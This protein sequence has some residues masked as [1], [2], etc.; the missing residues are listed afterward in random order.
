MTFTGKFFEAPSDGVLTDE[1]RRT[2]EATN[3]AIYKFIE[4]SIPYL[5]LADKYQTDSIGYVV[6]LNY[7]CARNYAISYYMGGTDEGYHEKAFLFFG[8]YEPPAF[9]AHEILHLFGA[10]DLYVADPFYGVSKDFLAYVKRNYPDDIM[11][12]ELGRS[13]KPVYDSIQ[14]EISRI[15]AYCLNW[16]DDIPELKQFPEFRR[17]VPAAFTDQVRRAAA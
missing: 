12:S 11:F 6:L 15:T 10:V 8:A 16:L 14:S 1:G 17:D 4:E 9:D 5:A 7:F 2:V 3:F 13:G